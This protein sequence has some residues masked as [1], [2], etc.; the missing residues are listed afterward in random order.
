[1]RADDAG[2]DASVT[3]RGMGALV[4]RPICGTRAMSRCSC[5]LG[6]YAESWAAALQAARSCAVVVVAPVVCVLVAC[7]PGFKDGADYNCMAD[8]SPTLQVHVLS[9]QAQAGTV[10]TSGACTQVH[11]GAPVGSRCPLW[12]GDMTS[13]DPNDRCEIFLVLDGGRTF[14]REVGATPWCDAPQTQSPTFD[15]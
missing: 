14:S 8:P 10:V 2:D 4:T 11:C 1:M 7:T 3:G 12:Q 9:L 13:K 15:E 6:S 5:V